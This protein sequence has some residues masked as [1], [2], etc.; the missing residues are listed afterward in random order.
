MAL[1]PYLES[2]VSSVADSLRNKLPTS[3]EKVWTN[4]LQTT[5]QATYNTTTATD[6]TTPTTT[7]DSSLTYKFSVTVTNE[8]CSA[9]ARVVVNGTNYDGNTISAGNTGTSTC[10]FTVPS[11]ATVTFQIVTTGTNRLGGTCTITYYILEKEVVY[12]FTVGEMGPAINYYN[13][14]FVKD[15][16]EGTLWSA[17]FSE[18]T[19][20]GAANQYAAYFRACTNLSEVYLPNCSGTLASWAFADCTNLTYISIPLV[21]SLG[22]Q[23]FINTNLSIFSK[24]M[25]R[26]ST[27]TSIGMSAFRNC[28][29]LQKVNLGNF[30]NGISYSTFTS[31]YSLSKFD[32]PLITF[33]EDAAFASCSNLR[34]MSSFANVSY[35]GISA[36]MGCTSLSHISFPAVTLVKSSAFYGCT[37]LSSAYIPSVVSIYDCAFQ[38]CSSLPSINIPSCITLGASAF[39]LC[40]SLSSIS[41]P[42][43]QSISYRTFYGC[44]SLTSIYLPSCTVMNGT[45]P[46][47]GCINLSIVDFSVLGG[48]ISAGA[49]SSCYN[50]LNLY[51]RGS[52]VCGLA[53]VNAFYSTPISGRTTST[54]G[55]YGSIHVRASLLD[56]YKTATN[57]INYSAR[58]VGDL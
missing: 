9:F 15:L 21:T 4:T 22:A 33:I 39:Y 10:S 52:T 23:A 50:L 17:P 53:N 13:N 26:D 47:M 31:C 38:L 46:F 51:L 2:Y 56:T 6:F 1:K 54:G 40:S 35:I 7:F 34:S 43:V 12:T 5:A 16:F 57:W 25:L 8:R 24:D 11:G 45:Q 42:L 29:N 41:T 18:I 48:S 36:F 58:F 49:F 19:R 30:S 3:Y 44:S 37:S 55:V 20:Y 32:A 14:Y 28:T 27:L